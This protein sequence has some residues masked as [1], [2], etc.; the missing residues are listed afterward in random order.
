MFIRAVITVYKR[1]K[2]EK[3]NWISAR[4]FPINN[5][6]LFSLSF[7][8]NFGKHFLWLEDVGGG[9]RNYS[10]VDRSLACWRRCKNPPRVHSG[11]RRKIF[12]GLFS[13][14]FIVNPFST[15]S[16][17]G[18]HFTFYTAEATHSLWPVSLHSGA[19]QI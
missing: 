5:C 9:G 12:L 15:L 16:V 14:Y 19:T 1:G 3:N 18:P 17:N 7:S 2:T 11:G 6:F 4:I 10:T 8:K 13:A